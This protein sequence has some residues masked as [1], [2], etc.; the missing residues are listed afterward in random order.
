MLEANPSYEYALLTVAN[1]QVG[2]GELDAARQTWERLRALSPL[3]ASMAGLGRADL[4]MYL[5][6]PR[7]AAEMLG[8][9]SKAD[10][11]AGSPGAGGGE[12]RG[13]CRGA[14]RGRQSARCCRRRSQSRV[15]PGTRER[16]VPC[17]AGY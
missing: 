16:A 14:L 7:E 4:E 6:R 10:E 2:A 1:S 17:G 13:T 5:G 12:I 11:A 8:E 15:P 3:G 9:G